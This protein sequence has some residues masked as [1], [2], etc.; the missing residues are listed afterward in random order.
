[1]S[2]KRAKTRCLVID[3]SI[4]HAAGDSESLA[5]T[6][7]RCSDFLI[8]VRGICHRM[9][10]SEAIKAEWDR[11]R[12]IFAGQ[13]LVSMMNLKKLR[14]VKDESSEALREAIAEHSR[15]ENIADIMLKDAHLIEAALATDLSIAALDDTAR[16]HFSRLAASYEALRQIIWVNPSIE[17]EQVIEWLNT[18]APAERSR[19]LDRYGR[20]NG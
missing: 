5:P 1:M 12:S 7:R 13:W 2:K 6:G 10:W 20:A 9:A 15:D 17:E 8:D 16:G 14:P 3:A 4:A 19:W 18:G 11:H